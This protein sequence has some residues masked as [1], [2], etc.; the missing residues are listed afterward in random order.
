MRKRQLL[1]KPA[2]RLSLSD[3]ATT[4]LNFGRQWPR[5]GAADRTLKSELLFHL[6]RALDSKAPGFVRRPM[7]NCPVQ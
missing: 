1:P 6:Q 4:R 7:R 5:N 2:I 3:L